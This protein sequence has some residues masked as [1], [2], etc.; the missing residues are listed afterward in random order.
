M[1][2]P[3]KELRRPADGFV[4]AALTLLIG[5][6]LWVH[7]TLPAK[8]LFEEARIYEELVERA[9]PLKICDAPESG[10]AWLISLEG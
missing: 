9:A 10:P 8:D 4:L 5:V 6:P 3:L 2:F 1:L 7:A